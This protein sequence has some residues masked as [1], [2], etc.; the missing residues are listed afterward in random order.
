[1]KDFSIWAFALQLRRDQ[2]TKSREQTG[3]MR[4]RKNSLQFFF[5]LFPTFFYFSTANIS[6]ISHVATTASAVT[7]AAS[8]APLTVAT[9]ADFSAAGS[10]LSAAA[11]QLLA[12]TADC[13][14]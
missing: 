14:S 12:L 8:H 7:I 4:E 3:S 2:N 9:A 5:V 10:A 6:H 1:M 11:A 13:E